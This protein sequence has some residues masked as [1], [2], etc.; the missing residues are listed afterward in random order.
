VF[1]GLVVGLLLIPAASASAA[2]YTVS[3]TVVDALGRPVAGAFVQLWDEDEINQ[4]GATVVSGAAGTFSFSSV[5]GNAS[6]AIEL[7]DT[8][9]ANNGNE[10]WGYTPITVAS[11]SVSGVVVIDDTVDVGQGTITVLD[12]L[13]GL[14]VEYA[15]AFSLV[16]YNSTD[17]SGTC[18]L[19]A[20]NGDVTIS[21]EGYLD[22]T[23][24]GLAPD[25]KVTVR[26]TLDDGYGV[27]SGQIRDTSHQPIRRDVAT[28]KPVQGT[29]WI[30][31]EEA[32]FYYDTA[33]FHGDSNG[34]F[35]AAVPAGTAMVEFIDLGKVYAHQWWPG[36]KFMNDADPITVTERAASL[37]YPELGKG[38]T[39]SGSVATDRG[40]LLS[41]EEEGQYVEAWSYRAQTHEW[42][43]VL[44]WDQL[45]SS[46]E[47]ADLQS[48]DYKIAIHTLLTDPLGNPYMSNGEP[49]FTDAWYKA[50]A[51]I[52]FTD[53][54]LDSTIS[55]AETVTV[56]TEQKL[57]GINFVLARPASV[58]KRVDGATRF[59]V[60]VNLARKG[61]D[62]DGDKS[63]PGVSDVIIAN[64]DNGKEADPLAA[65]GLA[66]LYDCP[67]LLTQAAKTPAVTKA[68]LVE[69]AKANPGVQIHIIGGTGSVPDARWYEWKAI[70][71][72]YKTKDRIE[73]AN[74][75][76]VSTN[77]AKRMITELGDP[78]ELGGVLIVAG[79]NLSGF[80]DALAASPIAY[81]NSMPMLSVRKDAVPDSVAKLL[82]GDL[83]D[84]PRYVV[85]SKAYVS[86]STRSKVKSSVRLTTSSN[87]YTAATQ[88][89][90]A[91]ITRHWLQPGSTAIAAKLPDALTGGVFSGKN[92]G[93][94][95]FTDST[96]VM[97]APTKT[98]ITGR[99]AQITH[100]WVFGGT[101]SVPAAQE[102]AY[103]NLV[104]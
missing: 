58:V 5:P 19:A 104:K 13:T 34:D 86:D 98:F 77:I 43:P 59:D 21:R 51:A 101:G 2:G 18:I 67:V 96:T 53:A 35:A 64:G 62:P 55:Q 69:I 24:T 6:Y 52:P 60:A 61:W 25:A 84:L 88:I 44:R 87:R 50:G 56:T 47:L 89:G 49:Q 71:G 68:A 26:L 1:L 16:D 99:K 46:Y 41:N 73:G 72:T 76:D 54:T 17:A 31:D 102:T 85:S 75:Y 23:L 81:T 37:I 97:Q 42:E 29:A 57:T 3:G 12:D 36:Y 9:D 14:P 93:I 94:M 40:W 82:A 7:S 90:T 28:E 74:R 27:I 45:G 4:I 66:G 33:W 39:I 20:T 100:G 38:A 48:G 91:A 95:L 80:Y 10:W 83:Y 103:R 22:K 32:G 30:Y 70:S 63:W 8:F 78:Y 92:A 79:D 11:A 65:A 15:D